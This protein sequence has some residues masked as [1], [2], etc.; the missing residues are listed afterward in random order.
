MLTKHW[1]QGKTASNLL[2]IFVKINSRSLIKWWLR[3]QRWL[4]GQESVGSNTRAHSVGTRCIKEEVM[5]YHTSVI[6]YTPTQAY[7][8]R[9]SSYPVPI[10]MK[11]LNRIILVIG[12]VKVELH[13]PFQILWIEFSY[14]LI[15]K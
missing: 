9:S 14:F 13:L 1:S 8:W 4:Q 3:I 6:L 10:Q 2:K 12:D 15:L 7:L 11:R 5:T